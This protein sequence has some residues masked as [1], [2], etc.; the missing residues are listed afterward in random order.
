[1]HRWGVRLPDGECFLKQDIRRLRLMSV[2]EA[3]YLVAKALVKV[4]AMTLTGSQRYWYDQM[5]KL[6]ILNELRQ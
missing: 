4:E 6:G 5:K 1:M 2:C 3:V